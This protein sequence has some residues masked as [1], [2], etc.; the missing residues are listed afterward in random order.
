MAKFEVTVSKSFKFDRDKV[1]QAIS[2][3]LYQFGG[4]V[5]AVSD[6]RVPVDTGNLRS[7]ARVETPVQDGNEVSV[8]LGYGSTAVDYALQ[9]HENLSPHVRWKRP[10]SGPKYLSGPLQEM[11]DQLP[12]EIAAAVREGLS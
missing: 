2:A 11:Q 1:V 6:E 7:T 3:K 4:K 9:V 12:G 10:G 5:I 8:T